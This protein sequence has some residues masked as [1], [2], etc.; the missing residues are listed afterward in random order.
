[1]D[2]GDEATRVPLLQVDSTFWEFV[3][4]G[5]VYSGFSLLVG[6]LDAASITQSISCGLFR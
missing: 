2:F 4:H 5:I 6:S 1:V 3:M